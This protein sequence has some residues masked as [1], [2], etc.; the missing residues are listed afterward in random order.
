MCWCDD[1]VVGMGD[2]DAAEK[3]GGRVGDTGA[4]KA[5]EAREAVDNVYRPPPRAKQRKRCTHVQISSPRAKRAKRS[6]TFT[7]QGRARSARNA[8]PY[9]DATTA[10]EKDESLDDV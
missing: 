7:S 1:V 9:V 3:V 6:T 10:R 4:N 5:R 8:F 2:G